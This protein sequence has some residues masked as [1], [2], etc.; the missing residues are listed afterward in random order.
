[1]D[2]K[3]CL[4][5]LFRMNYVNNGIYRPFKKI[6]FS[7]NK[8]KSRIFLIL[9]SLW[10]DLEKSYLTKLKTGCLLYRHYCWL[11]K[12]KQKIMKIKGV[13]KILCILHIVNYLRNTTFDFPQIFFEDQWQSYLK[14]IIKGWIN[15][16]DLWM[17]LKS[18]LK[19]YKYMDKSWL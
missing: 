8:I 1:M 12:K 3:R 4:K 11:Y 16:L 2:I 17:P 6:W 19:M 9:N 10:N 15:V 13:P 7:S 18:D 14:F 5:T